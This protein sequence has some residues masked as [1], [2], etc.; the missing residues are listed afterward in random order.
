[1]VLLGLAVG[2]ALFSAGPSWAQGQIEVVAP[3]PER[4][5]PP[6]FVSPGQPPE[7][8]RPR[9]ADFRPD[10][11]RTRHDPAFITPLTTT[12]PTGPKKGVR[13]GL[14]GWTAP[15]AR[16]NAVFSR[17]NSGLF[18]LGITFVWDVPIE[19]ARATPA[20]PAPPR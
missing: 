2:L 14:S 8:T 1:M 18:A 11:V 15:P 10:N 13:I 3:P 17:E 5:K 4:V 19:P 9:E 12:V 6:E 7:I 16:D 20:P